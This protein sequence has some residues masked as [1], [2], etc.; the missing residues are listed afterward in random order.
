MTIIPLIEIKLVDAADFGGAEDF[1]V[2]EIGDLGFDSRSAVTVGHT[3]AVEVV[4]RADGVSD[5]SRVTN[6]EVCGSKGEKGGEIEEEDQAVHGCRSLV[7][8][9]YVEDLSDGYI[10]L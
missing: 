5:S 8:E 7:F 4:G 9:A 10:G 1:R 2:V 3:V 6:M